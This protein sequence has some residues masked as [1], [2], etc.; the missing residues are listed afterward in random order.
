MLILIH[1]SARACEGVGYTSPLLILYVRFS[2]RGTARIHF[3]S[4][5]PCAYLQRRVCV[6]S[7]VGS[8]VARALFNVKASYILYGHI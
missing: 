1:H 6:G 8:R 5:L 4:K 2:C 3:Y 7:C